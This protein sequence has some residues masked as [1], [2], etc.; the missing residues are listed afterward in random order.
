M[1]AFGLDIGSSSIKLIEL[2]GNKKQPKLTAFGLAVNPVGNVDTDNEQELVQIAQ[3]IKKL[4]TDAGVK[5][6]RVVV[7]L[8]ESKVYTRVVEMPTLSESELASA[9]NWEAEQYI[10]IPIA[11]VQLDYRILSQPQA[12]GSNKMRVFLVAAPVA[13]VNRM[14][15][16]LELANL[17]LE[18]LE[19]EMLGVARAMTQQQNNAQ[20]LVHLGARTTDIGIVQGETVVFTRSISTGGMALTRALAADLGL[21][22][23]SAEQYK[24]TYGLDKNQLQGKVRTSLLGVFSSL[25]SE[26]KKAQH[27]Y[28]STYSGGIRR[29]ILSGGGAY[30]PEVTSTLASELGVEVVIGDPFAALNLTPQQRQRLGGIGAVF[31]V[32]VGMAL[33]EM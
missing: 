5:Q 13:V 10:P 32:A 22:V 33:R 30:L 19:T 26:F 21:E 15:K 2:T 12:I 29:L 16:I 6:R 4:T 24:R 25:V 1:P 20:L 8:P 9:I 17:E 18:A 3:A 14:V 11:E 28:A 27:F 31:T 23:A 7:G